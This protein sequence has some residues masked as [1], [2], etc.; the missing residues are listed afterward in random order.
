MVPTFKNCNV[1][2]G[3]VD[4]LAENILVADVLIVKSE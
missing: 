1:K 4:V 2:E 3:I